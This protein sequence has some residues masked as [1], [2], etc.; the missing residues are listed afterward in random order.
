MVGIGPCGGPLASWPHT[1][2]VASGER[3]PRRA[4]RHALETADID[5]SRRRIQ[6]HAC[7]TRVAGEPLH[8]RGGYRRGEGQLARRSPLETEE[9]LHRRGHLEVRAHSVLLR[10]ESRIERVIRQLDQRIGEAL[11]TRPII[12]GAAP[13]CQRLECAA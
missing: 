5:D 4:R 1:A 12:A 7:D 9:R 8:R 3:T 6:Q 11:V 10:D 13:P 2:T